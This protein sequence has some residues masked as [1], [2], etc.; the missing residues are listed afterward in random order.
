MHAGPH[1]LSASFTAPGNFAA[2]FGSGSLIVNP[3]QITVTAEAKSKFYGDADP[4][5]TYSFSPSLVAGDSFSGSLTRAGGENVGDYA[6]Q[7]GT[8][9]LSSN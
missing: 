9:A 7:Q 8:L 2:S 1:T 4:A 6:I 5:F 3:A